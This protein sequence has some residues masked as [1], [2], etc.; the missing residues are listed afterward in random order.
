MTPHGVLKYRK[1]RK[2]RKYKKYRSTALACSSV[3]K[4]LFLERRPSAF[5]G[6]KSKLKPLFCLR[7]KAQ[8]QNR[9]TVHSTQCI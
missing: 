2:Y 9:Y 7:D 8:R 6:S 4:Q 5:Q 1:Y 3:R